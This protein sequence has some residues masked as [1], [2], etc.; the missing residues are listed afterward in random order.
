MKTFTLIYY[1]EPA[2]GPG[3][4]LRATVVADDARAAIT[5]FCIENPIYDDLDDDERDD[6]AHEDLP[7]VRKVICAI[8]GDHDI[9]WNYD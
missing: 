4:Y 6:E 8:E 5:K 2:H 9:I 3:E 1:Q 7:E